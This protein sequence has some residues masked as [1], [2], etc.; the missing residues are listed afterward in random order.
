MELQQHK[1]REGKMDS[2]T[3]GKL[4]ILGMGNEILSDDAVGLVAMDM[5]QEQLGPEFCDDRVV[6][7]KMN[8][9]G[10]DLIY[11]TEGFDHL[12]VVDAYF[13]EDAVPGRVRVLAAEDLGDSGTETV[14]SAH[15]LSLPGALGVSK[16]LGYQTPDL[17]AAVVVDVGENCLVFGEQLSPGIAEAARE[18]A[19]II[20][21]M[22]ENHARGKHRGEQ[23]PTS[24]DND[25]N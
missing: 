18:A 4:L 7:K 21:E 3:S 2:R 1:F 20:V 11:E 9:G 19:G 6:F 15:L 17:E 25:R 8:T 14:D 22:V 13:A 24:T 12:I 23:I 16:K 10:L 5:V